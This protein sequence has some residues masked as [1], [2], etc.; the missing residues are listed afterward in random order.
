[1]PGCLLLCPCHPPSGWTCR[2]RCA[3]PSWR[4]GCSPAR[5]RHSLGATQLPSSKARIQTQAGLTPNSVLPAPAPA[6][7]RGRLSRTQPEP[8]HFI[9]AWDGWGSKCPTGLDARQTHCPLADSPAPVTKHCA[10]MTQQ[11]TCPPK[12]TMTPRESL[13]RQRE[14]GEVPD[15]D[16]TSRSILHSSNEPPP[17]PPPPCQALCPVLGSEV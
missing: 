11:G 10:E 12:G 8:Q 4:G 6:A 17:G 9:H 16:R 13:L 3:G 2:G 7:L 15:P 14:L 5:S 1:M